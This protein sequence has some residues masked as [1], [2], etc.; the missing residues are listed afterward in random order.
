ME[1]KKGFWNS[2]AS[3]FNV[4]IVGIL[5]FVKLSLFIRMLGTDASGINSLFTQLT[6]FLLITEAGLS[7]ATVTTLYKY[8]AKKDFKEINRVVSGSMLLFRK[9]IMLIFLFS[10]PTIIAMPFLIKDN[11]FSVLYLFLT[12]M[13]FLIKAVSPYIF[14]P[15]KGYV[16]ASNNEHILKMYSMVTTTLVTLAEIASLIL[17]KNFVITLLLGVVL[18]V[19]S[20]G[21]IYILITR[22]FKEIKLDF[23]TPNFEAKKHISELLKSS[24]VSTVAKALDPIIIST[25]M[26]LF[27][28]TV[29]SS[30]YYI[31]NFSVVILNSATGGFAHFLGAKFTRKDEN[32]HQ[33][34]RQFTVLT[35]YIV[36]IACLIFLFNC[37]HFIAVW[38]G[39]RFQVDMM[40]LMCFSFIL[41]MFTIMKPINILVTANQ[42]FNL[43][44]V[45]AIIET[46]INI[47]LSLILI[48]LLGMKGI[49]IATMVA[50]I[51]ASFWYFPVKSY[52]K[53]FGLSSVVYFKTQFASVA[54][55]GVFSLG[56]VFTQNI[57]YGKFPLT[58]LGLGGSILVSSLL[59]F[60]LIT[61]VYFVLFKEFRTFSHH[62]KKRL[63]RV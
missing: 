56:I 55:L 52:K 20:E 51:M 3:V 58:L 60:V 48:N 62:V 35:N 37:Q 32:M 41:Y 23:T 61:G 25:F 6:S 11:H 59:I 36:T 2:I 14:Q 28:T 15:I 22:K 39:E 33:V 63:K 19:A 34:F 29:Y 46:T 45:S 18:A 10:I 17:F 5:Q 49:L 31:V 44:S 9:I 26:G 7:L 21:I 4:V 30:Y 38:I 1:V 53:T 16:S 57:V 27:Y 50:F 13:L 8:V 12:F 40:T 24:I 47:S 42:Y 54:V 43:I